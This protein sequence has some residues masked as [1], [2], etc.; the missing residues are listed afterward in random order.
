MLG[1]AGGD[2]EG[3]GEESEES[4]DEFIERSNGLLV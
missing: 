1:E 2:V 4:S 3:A